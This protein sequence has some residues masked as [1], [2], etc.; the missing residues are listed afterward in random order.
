MLPET[1]PPTPR[2]PRDS[3]RRPALKVQ[4][5]VRA[6]LGARPAALGPLR[7]NGDIDVGEGI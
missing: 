4:T 3:T 7:W 5:H 2:T 6:G 1:A